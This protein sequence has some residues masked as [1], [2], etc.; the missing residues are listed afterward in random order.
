MCEAVA[1]D[2]CDSA[3]QGTC[4]HIW[5]HSWLSQGEVEGGGVLAL[6]VLLVGRGRDAAN[7]LRC[8]GLRSGSGSGL[9]LPTPNSAKVGKAWYKE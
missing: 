9:G 8:T 6:A 2:G 1:L 5:R 4:G 3:P 7:V